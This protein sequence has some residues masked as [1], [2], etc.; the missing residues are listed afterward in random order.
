MRSSEPAP[1]GRSAPYRVK[2]PKDCVDD[3]AVPPTSDKIYDTSVAAFLPVSA[4]TLSALYALVV[5]TRLETLD[6]SSRTLLAATGAG[7]ALI[8][9]GVLLLSR[10]GVVPVKLA[11]P[12]V[13]GMLALALV[14]SALQLVILR[15]PRQTTMIMLLVVAVGAL[16]LAVRWVVAMLYLAWS[17][18]LVGAL[19]VGPSGQWPHFVLG[20]VGATAIAVLANWLRRS[21]VSD[22]ADARAA[23]T[24]AAVRD[25]L[26]GVANRRGLAMIGAQLVEQARRQGDAVHCIFVDIDG[27]KRV[28][29]A[30]GTGA[31]DEVLVAVADALR[32]VTRA[33]DVVAR[34]GGDEFCIV[35]PGPGMPPLELE[36]RVRDSV[37]QHAPV[38]PDLWPSRVSAGGAMLAPWDAGSLETLLGKADQEM[39]LRRSL[40]RESQSGTITPSAPHASAE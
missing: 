28:N 34:W 7:C 17:A 33:T 20:L 5:A 25:Q 27:L 2:V 14:D 23:A 30:L 21:S 12:A 39:Y 36:R 38:P 32:E 29:D 22:L 26:T 10:R 35:G 1:L 9:L 4:A 15:E 16:L 37:N 18:W 11:Q 19:V 8:F 24:A 6:G 13:A 40:R 31:G 3:N